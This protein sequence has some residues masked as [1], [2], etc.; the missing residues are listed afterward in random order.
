LDRGPS[1]DI[2]TSLRALA[3][4]PYEYLS[5]AAACALTG[6]DR[7]DFQPRSTLMHGDFWIGNILLDPSA[8]R[9]FVVIDWRGCAIDGYAIFDL[10]KF[11]ESANLGARSLKKELVEHA[12]ILGCRIHDTRTYLLAALGHVWL[13]LDQ[14]P[15]ERFYA[16]ARRNLQ[17]LECAIN[18]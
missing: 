5:T 15:P 1:E 13:H 3:N 14:F 7:G 6:L 8:S 2:D 10:V 9:E 17:T 12:K 18:G 16:M 11:A 4:C